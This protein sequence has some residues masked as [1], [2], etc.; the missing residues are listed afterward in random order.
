MLNDASDQ[1]QINELK[2]SENLFGDYENFEEFRNDVQL[3]MSKLSKSH[4]QE[5][6]KN[7]ELRAEINKL[8]MMDESLAS[9]KL[10][11]CTSYA[12]MS[13]RLNQYYIDESTPI[14]VIDKIPIK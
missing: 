3:Q 8:N 11:E 14:E 7:C 6:K 5:V 9:I 10:S 12:E 1:K 2:N 13:I 4:W